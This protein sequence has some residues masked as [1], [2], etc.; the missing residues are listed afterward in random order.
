[1]PAQAK[2]S[3]VIRSTLIALLLTR[4][5]SRVMRPDVGTNLL[6]FIFEIQGPV[7][8]ALIEKEITDSVRNQIPNINILNIAIRESGSAVLVNIVYS[9]FGV[10]DQTGEIELKR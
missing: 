9:I 4:K 6:N 8:R 5:R 2:G 3:D 10:V 7:L 1:M